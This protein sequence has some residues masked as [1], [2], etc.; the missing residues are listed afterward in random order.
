MLVAAARDTR[1]DDYIDEEIKK[2]RLVDI[3]LGRDNKLKSALWDAATAMVTKFPVK[4]DKAKKLQKIV[5]IAYDSYSHSTAGIDAYERGDYTGAAQNALALVLKGAVNLCDSKDCFESVRKTSDEMLK[6]YLSK[7][8]EGEYKAL[9]EKA[10][11]ELGDKSGMIRKIESMRTDADYAL[12]VDVGTAASKGWDSQDYADM[13]WTLGEGAVTTAWPPAAGIIAAVRVTKEGALAAH[14]FVVDDSTQTLYTVYKQNMDKGVGDK[15]YYMAL[16]PYQNT[17]SLT[18]AR[19]VMAKNLHKPEVLKSLSKANLIKAKAGTLSANDLDQ[20]E[21]WGFLHKQFDAWMKAEKSN[22]DFANYA[23]SLRDDYRNMI[24]P[25]D[26]YKSRNPENKGFTDRLS[27][28]WDNYCPDEVARFRDYVKAR[29]DI[30]SELLRWSIGAESDSCTSDDRLREESRKLLCIKVSKGDQAYLD[31][32][33]STAKICGW[34]LGDDRLGNFAREKGIR[35]KQ[36][37]EMQKVLKRQDV[38]IAA[39]TAIG[40][41]DILNC[42]CCRAGVTSLGVPCGYDTKPHPDKSP[43]CA[44]TS[45]PCIG[46]YWGCFRY[47]MATSEQAK[48]SCGVYDAIKQW[49]STHG[50]I[51]K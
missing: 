4:S 26:F 13:L 22:N 20:S 30:E 51:C 2:M 44:K 34:K 31:D 48:E 40:R 6:N 1:C 19:Q 35:A 37:A 17:H 23:N 18:K 47:N 15:D 28:W 42:L 33:L 16:T 29:A 11:R 43:S 41:T 24:C 12:N 14:D 49:K 9:L 38:V 25:Y 10:S 39:M 8:S 45:P 32:V 7:C 46:G 21:I 5:I 36:E 3:T 50:P 27:N